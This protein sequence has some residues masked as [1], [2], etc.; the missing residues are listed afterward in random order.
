MGRVSGHGLP[1]GWRAAELGE[2][3]REERIAITKTDQAYT[4]MPYLGLEHIEPNTGRILVN[5]RD[6]RDSDSKSNNFRFTPEHV[7]YGKLRPYLN[8]VALPEFTGR[9]T[10][11]IIPLRPLGVDRRWLAWL[12]RRQQVVDYA[13]RG[14]TGSRMPRTSMPYLLALSVAVPPPH[15]Q[16]RIV[17]RLERQIGALDRVRRIVAGSLTASDGVAQAL[18]RSAFPRLPTRLAGWRWTTLGEVC[19]IN[20]PRPRRLRIPPNTRITFVPMAA[21]SDEAAAVTQPIVRRYRD[22]SRGYTYMQD[23]DVIFAKITPCMQNGKHA[24]VRDTLTGCAFGSTEFHVLRPSA[25]LDARFLHAF[26]LRKE[27]LR[28]AEGHFKGTAGQQR[29]PK[30]FLASTPFPLPPVSEQR[31]IIAQLTR[32]SSALARARSAAQGQLRALGGLSQAAIRQAFQT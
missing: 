14:K 13:M 2:I 16:R 23:G 4:T 24:V 1:K 12:L 29:V 9:C 25:S 10:T 20:P 26:L 3:C 27:F 15:V 7:L 19:Q 8:K 28:D 17:V 22:V 32:G 21:V 30:E 18:F 6:A 5:E 31:R 11:E